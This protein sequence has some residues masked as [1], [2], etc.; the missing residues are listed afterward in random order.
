MT[1][2]GSFGSFFG[3]RRSEPFLWQLKHVP[4]T[5]G[6]CLSIAIDGNCIDENCCIELELYL[7]IFG[8]RTLL[9]IESIDLCATIDVFGSSLLPSS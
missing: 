7:W 1:T 8:S 3:N 6:M 9:V 5:Y 4:I 2:T